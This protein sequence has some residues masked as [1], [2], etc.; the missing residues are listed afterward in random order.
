MKKISIVLVISL[1]ASFSMIAM[2]KNIVFGVLQSLRNQTS[3]KCGSEVESFK[4]CTTSEKLFTEVGKEITFAVLIKNTGNKDVKISN[5]TPFEVRVFN[6][7]S[8]SIPT[9]SQ[10]KAEENKLKNVNEGFIDKMFINHRYAVE[11]KPQQNWAKTIK[12]S[13]EYDLSKKG[14]YFVE[15]KSKIPKKQQI[16]F[17]ELTLD[18]IEIIVK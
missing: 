3:E 18:K 16:G 5:Q 9:I 13:K 10:M 6:E 8:E 14:K 7:K 11:L 12:L 1:V 15:V 2:P 4:L 17:I